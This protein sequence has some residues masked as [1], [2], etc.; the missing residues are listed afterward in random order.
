MV[1]ATGRIDPNPGNRRSARSLL[2]SRTVLIRRGDFMQR[3]TALV[4]LLCSL[5]LVAAGC[6]ST[7]PSREIDLDN[8]PAARPNAAVGRCRAQCRRDYHA[9]YASCSSASDRPACQAASHEE[10]RRCTASCSER[11]VAAR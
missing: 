2:C 6:G 1:A 8:V 7:R 11:S 5:W 9:G 4:R 3:P 10:M